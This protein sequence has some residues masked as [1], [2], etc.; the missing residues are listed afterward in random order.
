MKN[1]SA[2]AARVAAGVSEDT[3]MPQTQHAA[4]RRRACR[5]A[6]RICRR[7]RLR[8]RQHENAAARHAAMR[9][10]VVERQRKAIYAP[11]SAKARDVMPC[12]R[13]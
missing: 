13:C 3:L 9:A 6:N 10:A 11:L 1:D 8:R 12:W 4:R 5:A 7:R 2:Y